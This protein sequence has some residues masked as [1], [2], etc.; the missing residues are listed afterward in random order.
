[1]Q[2]SPWKGEQTLLLQRQEKV[3][4]T[5]SADRLTFQLGEF[6]SGQDGGV[7]GLGATITLRSPTEDTDHGSRR[8]SSFL[9][10]LTLLPL[11]G[12]NL[13]HWEVKHGPRLKANA[14]YLLYFFSRSFLGRER[15]LCGMLEELQERWFNLINDFT[16]YSPSIKTKRIWK[17]D[18]A[19]WMVTAIY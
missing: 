10:S 5:V 16:T 19:I 12:E 6:F 18:M 8:S 15:E 1:M 7:L 4:M 2:H 17:Q 11:P 14:L 3:E 9:S 13:L